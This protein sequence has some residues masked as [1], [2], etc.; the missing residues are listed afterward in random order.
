LVDTVIID[1][2]TIQWD[3]TGDATVTEG[4]IAAYTV[5]YSGGTIGAG[6][7]ATIDL[8]TVPGVTPLPDATEGVDYNSADQTLTFLGGGPTS[9]IINVQTNQDGDFEWDEEYGVTISSPSVGTIN[10]DRV[11]TTLQDDETNNPPTATDNLNWIFE[12]TVTPV[13]GNVITDDDGF[14]VDSDPDVVYTLTISEI[15]GETNPANNVTT[16]LGTLDWDTNGDYDYYVDNGNPVVQALAVGEFRLDFFVYTLDDGYGGTDIANLTIMINGTNDPVNAVDDG[17]PGFVTDE[18]TPFTTVD[19]L[20]NDTDPDTN[21]VLSVDSFDNTGAIGIITDNGDGTFDYDPSGQF[22]G[23]GVGEQA[24]DFFNYTVTDGLTFDTAMVTIIITGVNDAPTATDDGPVVFAEDS[25]PNPIDV[26]LNDNDPDATDTLLVTI[27]TQGGNGTVVITGGG[28]G[29]TY[30]PNANYFGPDTFTYTI[31]DG[32]GGTDTATVN[33]TII[34]DNADAPDAVNDDA[35]VS[36]DSGAN[37]LD[38]LFNDD[39]VDGNTVT[40]ITVTNGNHGTVNIT[41]GGTDLTYT[42]D[43]DFYGTDTFTYTIDDGTGL[44]DTATVTVSVININDDPQSNDD[45]IVVDEDSGA[46]QIDV[47]ANDGF[48]PDP[49]ETLKVTAATQGAHGTVAILSSGAAV[50]YAPDPDFNG[51]DSFTYTISDGNGGTSTATVSVTVNNVND[52]PTISGTH[53]TSA[54]EGD[55]YSVTY[56]ATDID[57][58]DTLTWSVVTG[59]TWL[60]MGPS[61]GTLYGVAAHGSFSVRVMVADGNGGTDYTE[62][63]LLVTRLDSD[64]DGVPDDDDEFP[65]DANETADSDDDGTGDNADTD[66]DNDGTPDTEDAFPTDPAETLDTDDDGIGNNADTD[67]DGDGVADADDPAP[68]DPSIRADY[69]QPWP[70]W[71]VLGVIAIAF[72]L[73]FCCLIFIRWW[74]GR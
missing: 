54:E 18:N 46:T 11:D 9:Q 61:N 12:D 72:I 26:R 45:S 41:N 49:A 10:V 15:N 3:I 62:F 35:T 51:F 23:L 32:H 70:Y 53:Q 43:P 52:P 21:D 27:V 20:A 17:G 63:D 44:N 50:T 14:G 65:D 6:H 71:W 40:I 55:A 42:P 1:A 60:L 8:D 47:L 5:S 34:N 16:F 2:S 56:I 39:D 58:G 64:D 67:D 73:G 4:N 28:T 25:G 30:E 57:S 74:I 19:V 29:L 59:A 38:V 33:V 24:L 68:L 37:T 48:A 36:E 22:E 31:S 7:S 66:D 69:D 13:S